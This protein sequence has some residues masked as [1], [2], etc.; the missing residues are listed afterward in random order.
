MDPFTIVLIA[1]LGFAVLLIADI[2]MRKPLGVDRAPLLPRL[3]AGAALLGAALAALVG[4]VNVVL[5]FVGDRVTLAV[6]VIAGVDTVPTELRA[7]TEASILSGAAQQTS[8]SLTV[9]GLDTV[10]LVLVALQSAATTAVII[11]VLAMVARLSQQSMSA[12]PFS[13][14]LSRLFT[15]SGGALAIGGMAA[16]FAG[17]AAGARTHEQLFFIR[18]GAIDGVANVPPAW[19]IE[20]WPIGVGL[21]LIVMAGLIRHGVRLQSDTKGLV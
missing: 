9:S 3:V 20:V 19:M 2:G 6:P 8:L 18:D 4:V 17:L 16:Q 21:V 10:T 12:A 11:T 1:M 5:T 14:S 7:S 13:T 15:V